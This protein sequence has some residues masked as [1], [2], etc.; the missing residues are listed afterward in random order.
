MQESSFQS[1]PVCGLPGRRSTLLWNPSWKIEWVVS[2][3]RGVVAPRG[4]RGRCTKT[5]DAHM[6][7][8]TGS[9]PSPRQTIRCK[10]H[11][12]TKDGLIH[13]LRHWVSG[14]KG[15]CKR[16]RSALLQWASVVVII[17]SPIY[18]RPVYRQVTSCSEKLRCR[19]MKLQPSTTTTTTSS[20]N[21]TETH[22][23]SATIYR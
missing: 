16:L 9:T 21:T 18:H 3:A 20:F 8:S 14:K 17:E 10:Y 4:V 15:L 13:L 1:A 19:S 6:D 22:C 23:N 7:M 5:M 11:A 12:T 2:F